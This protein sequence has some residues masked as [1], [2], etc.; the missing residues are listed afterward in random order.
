MSLTAMKFKDLILSCIYG[1]VHI[2]NSKRMS[3]GSCLTFFCFF[4]L[5]L[6]ELFSFLL[7]SSN[8]FLSQINKAY[9]YKII[10]YIYIVYVHLY[11]FCNF[12]LYCTQ[13]ELIEQVPMY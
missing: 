7:E 12:C 11:M 13:I 2:S 4:P 10:F 8:P 3:E 6:L 1:A 9:I 5:N